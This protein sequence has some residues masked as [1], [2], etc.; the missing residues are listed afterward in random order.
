MVD[1]DS[2]AVPVHAGQLRVGHDAQRHRPQLPQQRRHHHSCHPH[3]RRGGRG[4]GLRVRTLEVRRSRVAVRHRSRTAQRPAP[5]DAGARAPDVQQ[6]RHR[7]DVPRCVD[8]PRRLCAA[9]LHLS[10]AQL[11]RE[12]ARGTVRVRRHRRRLGDAALLAD[13]RPA[14]RPG[15]CGRRRVPV[16]V[17]LERPTGLPDLPRR[18]PGRRTADRRGVEPRELPRRRLGGPHGG[19]IIVFFSLQRFFVRGMLAGAIK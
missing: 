3:H 4:R 15:P 12:R 16:H 8:R 13:R 6:P 7:G 9:V 11:L 18:K 5:D 10:A 14:R 1:G 17:R 19:P 2:P